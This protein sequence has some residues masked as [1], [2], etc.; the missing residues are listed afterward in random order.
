M[1]EPV[2]IRQ[3]EENSAKMERPANTSEAGGTAVP[4]TPATSAASRSRR[5]RLRPL[6]FAA[7][8]VVLVVGGYF[9][10][11]GGR[12][13]SVDN[14]YVEARIA[15][16]ST[17]VAGTVQSIA[18]HDNEKVKVGQ[19]LYKLDPTSFRIALDAANAKLD[20]ARN[21][22]L[23]LKATYRQ[24]QAEVVQAQAD[25][26]FYQDA[27]DRAQK[28][29]S[30]ATASRA[31]L[32]QASHDLE[33]AK[34][35]VDVAKAQAAAT[36][37]KLNGNPDLPADQFP[38]V[39]QAE[40]SVADAQRQLSHTVVKAP[41]DGIATNVNAIQVGT[42]LQP[43]QTAFSLVSTEDMWIDANPKET[44]L[45]YVKPGQPVTITV[46]TYPG[47]TWTGKVASV[48]PASESS[49]SLLPAQNSS[50]NWVKVVQRIPLR[51]AIN[52][53]A[54]K[55]QLRAGMSTEVDIDT[56]HERGMPQF[57]ETLL[58]R[59]TANAHE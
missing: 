20:A 1:S 57:V 14:A 15:G 59:S 2:K 45:T 16:V 38:E 35:K 25:L 6:L 52:A 42:Y 18:V 26:P 19:V 4:A 49:F 36:L 29:V 10:F 48:S 22:L 55:P 43:A 37:A 40:A 41:F 7:L 50:G 12:Y 17:D 31:T 24:D 21:D 30:S 3:G 23:T 5:S 8:P 13:V 32:D 39:M 27:Y 11:T 56:N 44:E 33:S 54:D 28:L 51:V 46:D 58:G 47:V 53:E 34:Q 9:Y